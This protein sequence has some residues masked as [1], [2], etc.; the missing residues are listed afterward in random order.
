MHT[1]S[2]ASCVARRREGRVLVL[3]FTSGP[4]ANPLHAAMQRDLIAALDEA[5]LD[6]T[7]GALVL[8]GGGRTF[9]V[10]ADLSAMGEVGPPGSPESIGNQTADGMLALTNPLV[11]RLRRFPVPVVCALNGAAAGAGVG[12]ALSADFTIGAASAMLLLSFMPKLGIAPDMGCSWY[13]SRR[14]GPAR[15]AALLLLGD[16]IGSAEAAQSGLIHQCVP[17]AEL[18]PQALAL[19][20]R[21]SRLPAHAAPEIRAIVDEAW[22]QPLP[23]QLALEAARQRVLLDGPAFAEGVAAFLARREPVFPSR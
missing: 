12:L 15:A 2:P 14:L 4:K 22:S 16:P 5:A 3:T 21:L 17:D 1:P 13:L 18:M 9:C 6:T 10:G 23:A 19:A 11:M 8:T 20:H 7:V